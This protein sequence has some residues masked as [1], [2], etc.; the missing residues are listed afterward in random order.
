MTSLSNT[1][2]QTLQPGQSITFDKIVLKTGC[3]ECYR[4]STSSVKL[5][6]NGVYVL[7]FH[8]NISGA[9]A[10]DVVDLAIQVGGV[11]LPETLMQYVTV[12]A[13]ING[14]VSAETPFENCCGDYDRVTVTNVGSIPVNVAANSILTVYRRS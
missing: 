9:A 1:T 8:G 3:G 4:S 7:S 11:T 10:G 14:N 6:C 12:T 2:A 13:A 5:R